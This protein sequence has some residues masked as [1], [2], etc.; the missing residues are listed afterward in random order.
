VLPPYGSQAREKALRRWY[1]HPHNTL[2]QGAFSGL[3]SRVVSTPFE[4]SGPNEEESDNAQA[5]LLKAHFGKGFEWLF[6]VTVLNYL[7]HDRGAWWE[8]IGYGD[9]DSE[10]VGAPVA[11]A[12]LDPLR[13]YPTGEREYPILYWSLNGGLHRMHHSRVVQLVHMPDHDDDHPDLGLSPLS[14]AIAIV[15]R[16][17][18]MDRYIVSRLDDKPK[19]GI[20]ALSGVNEWQFDEAFAKMREERR[21]DEQPEWGKV[22]RVF[23]HDPQASVDIKW[24]TFSDAPEKFDFTAYVQ[25]DVNQLALALGVDKQEL[26]EL[27]GGGIGTGTQ[28]QIL[29]SK[30]RGKTFGRLLKGIERAL[31]F[32]VLPPDCEFAFKYRDP[33]EDMERANIAASY[34]ATITTLGG[35]ITKDEQRKMLANQVEAFRDVL[36]DGAGQVRRADDDVEPAN[37][38]AT[39]D[40]TAAVS[41]VPMQ[42]DLT[43]KQHAVKDWA[44]TQS[45]AALSFIRLV[46]AAREGS[47][48]QRAF[49][50]RLRQWLQQYGQQAYADGVEESE[51]ERRPLD[52]NERAEVLTWLGE[53]Q[54]YI[55][56]F[57]AEVYDKGIRDLQLAQRASAWVDNSLGD[58]RFRAAASINGNQRYRWDMDPAAENCRTCRAL[59]G[60]VHR[61]KDY[62]SR[63]LRPKSTALECFVGCRCTLMPTDAPTTGRLRSVPIVRRRKQRLSYRAFKEAVHHA[64]RH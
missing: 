28:S 7:R 34:A 43:A 24:T 40:D 32:Y 31:N 48:T 3:A 30:S 52:T 16:E 56:G 1:R 21:L 46:N 41:S 58:I 55:D 14:Q 2:I 63:G 44:V 33:Q 60:Q 12:A 49:R 9:P 38:D 51:G 45:E 15:E 13:C 59:D 10:L 61:L 64:H 11:V 5:M 22:V 27:T 42:P 23:G 47:G 62:L 20:M 26:W 54:G 6:S 17:V 25:V 8:L 53:Q 39:T 36:L 4:I 29:A 35:I 50:A 18:L 19:P 37:A 57:G